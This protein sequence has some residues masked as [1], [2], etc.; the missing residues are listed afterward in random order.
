MPHAQLMP[1]S[2]MAQRFTGSGF[3]IVTETVGMLGSSKKPL[4]GRGR[5]FS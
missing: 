2:R 1:R 4:Q 3:K 5:S